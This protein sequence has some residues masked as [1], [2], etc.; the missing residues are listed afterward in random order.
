MALLTIND[1]QNTLDNTRETLLSATDGDGIVSRED[2]EQLSDETEDQLEKDFLRIF[3]HDFLLKLDDKSGVR[4][5]AALIDRGMDFIHEQI[6]PHLSIEI[7]SSR[8]TEENIAIQHDEAFEIS[9][10]LLTFT[11]DN[12]ALNAHEL[13][14]QIGALSEGLYFDD[15]GSE[16]AIAINA[17]FLEHLYLAISPESFIHD[18]GLDPASPQAAVSRFLDRGGAGLIL[19]RFIDKHEGE[20]RDKARAVVKLMEE[21]LTDIKVITLGEPNLGAYD[22]E[23]P[24]YVIGRGK[25]GN[26]AG[27]E[28]RVIWT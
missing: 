8:Q 21:N 6:V 4:V 28:S 27:F 22:S 19:H 14:D 5:T 1:L 26:I 17:F 12:V 3:Y 10:K 9:H 11:K 2:F 13:R 23:H 16:A 25:D 15:L 18:L 7:T 20:L 24:L